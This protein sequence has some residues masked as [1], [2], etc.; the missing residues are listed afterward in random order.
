MLDDS[1]NNPE[2]ENPI[3]DTKTAAKATQ[4]TAQAAKWGIRAVKLAR[5]FTPAGAALLA[6][7]IAGKLPIAGPLARKINDLS[8]KVVIGTGAGGLALL[9][10]L[11]G[12]LLALAGYITVGAAIGFAIGGPVG[13]VVGGAIGATVGPQI[14]SAIGNYAGFAKSA[15]SAIGHGASSI[16]SG[17]GNAISSVISSAGSAIGSAISGTF[18][19]LGGAANFLTSLGGLSLPTSI[20]TVPLAVGIGG[21]GIGSMFITGFVAPAAFFTTEGE[22]GT[23]PTPGETE[24]FT[25]TKTA[26][27]NAIANQPPGAT[28]QIEF[29]I[30]LTAKGTKLINITFVD[31]AKGGPSGS[32]SIPTPALSCTVPMDPGT[33]CTQTFIIGLDSRFNDSIVTNTVRATVSPEGFGAQTTSVVATVVV[34][35]PP[36]QC[37]AAWPTASGGNGI[38]QGP[39]GATSHARLT[40]FGE[41]SIDVGVSYVPALATFDGVV[42][43]AHTL[44]DNGYGIFVDLAGTCNGTPFRA[45]WAHLNSI[46]SSIAPGANVRLGQTLGTTGETGNVFGAHLHYSF[47]GGL[48]MTAPYIPTDVAFPS[49]NSSTECNVN[50]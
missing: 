36:A 42:E 38:T 14:L 28:K 32:I 11:L 26:F 35:S 7:D 8:K 24:Y 12:K 34:G 33:V 25:L 19:A 15:T 18:G 4:K 45:R 39:S 48:T 31:E 29:T 3:E 46:N 20:V 37:P 13:A 47:F 40:T 43:T 49:C 6:R 27:P 44:N 30:T 16:V 23:S 1:S 2:A 50:W 41:Q 9:L 17:I 5:S 10:Y 22:L 21:V